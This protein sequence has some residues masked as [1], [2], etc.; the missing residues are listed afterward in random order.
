MYDN[1]TVTVDVQPL[2]NAHEAFDGEIV[3]ATVFSDLTTVGLPGWLCDEHAEMSIVTPQRIVIDPANAVEVLAGSP[4][5]LANGPRRSDAQRRIDL[6][7]DDLDGN[8]F[9]Y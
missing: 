6:G 3:P 5:D 8:D 7:L 2:C 4:V 9:P 1:D